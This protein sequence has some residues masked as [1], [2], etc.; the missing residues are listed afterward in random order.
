MVKIIKIGECKLEVVWPMA[1]VEAILH[2]LSKAARTCAS[3][4][5][6]L[7]TE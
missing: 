6:L 7:G 5:F 3:V 4:F 2:K 1:S